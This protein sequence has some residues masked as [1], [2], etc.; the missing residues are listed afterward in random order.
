MISRTGVA[1][2]E[3]PPGK[4]AA[5]G[6]DGADEA[7]CGGPVIAGKHAEEQRGVKLFLAHRAYVA[8]FDLRVTVLLH[9]LTDGRARRP[10]A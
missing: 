1:A 6:V 9:E 5:D 4:L 10:P 8:A 7:S 3:R 2:D